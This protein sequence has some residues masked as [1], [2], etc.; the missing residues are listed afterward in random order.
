MWQVHVAQQAVESFEGSSVNVGV[1]KVVITDA[2][3]KL[4]SN[5]GPIVNALH[6][7]NHAGNRALVL[8]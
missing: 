4:V 5:L 2:S 8:E 3:A 1:L 7:D 6:T